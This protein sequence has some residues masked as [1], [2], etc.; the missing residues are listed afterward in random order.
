MRKISL[1]VW[2]RVWSGW[3]LITLTSFRFI[4]LIFDLSTK[5]LDK[6]RVLF[7]QRCL[8][9]EELDDTVNTAIVMCQLYG[10]FQVWNWPEEI[11]IDRKVMSLTCGFS[12]S[13]PDRYV[14]LFGEKFF[15]PK[16]I[17][18]SVPIVEQLQALKKVVD[19]GKVCRTISW[20]L[21][22]RFK[23]VYA[24]GVPMICTYLEVKISESWL[25]TLS[26]LGM[27]V[28]R[29]KLRLE[30][31]NSAMLLSNSTF[32]RL[33]ASK[34]TTAYLSELH[35]KVMYLKSHLCILLNP[36][37]LTWSTGTGCKQMYK[38]I[39]SIEIWGTLSHWGQKCVSEMDCRVAPFFH[40]RSSQHYFSG[41]SNS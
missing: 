27:W 23:T 18:E 13:R 20:G 33:S 40:Y 21:E 5:S 25:A 39:V 26:R 4:G 32:Q 9:D 16:S 6:L 24:Q 37:P 36:K 11:V 31:W 14:P 22:T 10:C 3:G 12:V 17:R 8:S 1:Q 7:L 38:F 19:Q 15:N 34:T 29:M 35:L 30:W 28:S 41:L 2:R